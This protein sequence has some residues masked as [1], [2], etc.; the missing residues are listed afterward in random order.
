MPFGCFP[1][2]GRIWRGVC[3]LISPP[4]VVRGANRLRKV[5]LSLES[6]ATKLSALSSQSAPTRPN[7]RRATRS[8]EGG[9]AAMMAPARR[10]IGACTR[11]ARTNPSMVSHVT[12]VVCIPS[13]SWVGLTVRYRRRILYPQVGSRRPH[14]QRRR[15]RRVRATPLCRCD[16]LQ[17]H[18]QDEHH[19]W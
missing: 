8:A 6:P 4:M 2:A 13:L 10:A 12:V 14:P 3:Y 16:C 11:C 18:P 17:Q 19:S 7:G 15:P 9:M 1:A 5:H